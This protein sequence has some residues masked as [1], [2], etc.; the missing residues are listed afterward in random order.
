MDMSH[1]SLTQANYI[2]QSLA[3]DK[4]PLG[5]FL[6][7]GCPV[8]IKNSD[9][10]PL[11]PDIAG[12]TKIVCERLLRSQHKE[13]FNQL[14][15]NL[16]SD[17]KKDPDVEEMLGQIRSLRYVVGREMVRGLTCDQLDNLDQEICQI[18]FDIVNK[19]LPGA[20][21]PYHKV[22]SWIGSRN[23]TD[24][25]EVFTPNYDLLMEQAFEETRVPYFDGFI[26]SNRTFFDPHAMEE[27]KLPAR[28][29]RLWKLHGSVN[30]RQDEKGNVSRGENCTHEQRRVI[31]PSHLKYDQSRKMPYLAMI[32]RLRAFLKKPQ[33]VLIMCGYSFRDDHL[34]EIMVQGLQGNA[35]AIIFSLLFGKLEQYQKAVNLAITRTNLS[36]LAK[37]A[38]VIS[39]RRTEWLRQEFTSRSESIAVQWAEQDG[40]GKKER[41][42]QASF[43]LGDFLTFGSFLEDLI[44]GYEK[45]PVS[46]GSTAHAS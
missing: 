42:K 13:Y 17:G 40:S 14:V 43:M 30:W 23:G 29:S 22:A 38:A 44:G 45:E 24:P 36:L 21:S 12:I 18:I 7:A 28:W 37:D 27:D 16:E 39:G 33:A 41:L 5:I 2:R 20:G 32:D 31:H 8:A 11:I 6:G 15:K 1:N 35:T 26:G 3:H 4:R 9:K 34:N 25:V 46:E 19:S 10:Q